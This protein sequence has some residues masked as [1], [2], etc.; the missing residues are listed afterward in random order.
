LAVVWYYS[1][2]DANEVSGERFRNT[3]I[4]RFIGVVHVLL[5]SWWL[6]RSIVHHITNISLFKLR[7]LTIIAYMS[8]LIWTE[9]LRLGGSPQYREPSSIPLVFL[10]EATTCPL[11]FRHFVPVF[12][13]FGIGHTAA[14]FAYYGSS[15]A[16]V[17]RSSSSFIQNPHMY[18]CR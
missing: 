7:V 5:M 1:A 15:T 8:P 6:R 13:F 17:S 2:S 18:I 12:L 4:A 11:L 9:A 3:M 14:E 16:V 10:G